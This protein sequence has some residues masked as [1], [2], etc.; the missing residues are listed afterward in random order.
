MEKQLT[1]QLWISHQN[2][3]RPE[4]VEEHFESVDRK[5]LFCILIMVMVI[6]ICIKIHRVTHQ[7]VH[8]WDAKQLKIKKYNLRVDFFIN[9]NI[10]SI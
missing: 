4:E 1:K 2:P 8:F 10:I 5:E 6:Q 3:V 7:K 9:Q